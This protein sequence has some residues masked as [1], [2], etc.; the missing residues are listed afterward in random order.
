MKAG[1][2]EE[3]PPLDHVAVVLHCPRSP[4]NIGASAR[5]MWNMGL[6]RLIVVD[7]FRWDEEATARMAT[8]EALHIVRSVEIRA[9]LEDALAPFG[10]VVGTTA[11][12]GGMR[13][14]LWTPRR[15]AERILDAGRANRIALLF[16]PEDRGLTNQDLRFCQ[17]LVR[18]PTSRFGSL[19]LAQAVLILCYELHL[20]S[21]EPHPVPPA[22][23]L[24][25]AE[26]LER[27]YADLQEILVRISMISPEHPESEMMKV[28]RFLSRLGLLSREVRMIR[29]L[30]RQIRW[31]GETRVRDELA[32]R[33]REKGRC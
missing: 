13:D 19:N 29:G 28:R 8:R 24:A 9:S 7:P 26:E 1:G 23:A 25:K 10:F 16:G 17:L 3:M 5:A 27:M 14:L 15:A 31:Y 6:S 2:K 21:N 32:R 20:A 11:R 12:T 22:P 4:E 18:I 33:L 30:A